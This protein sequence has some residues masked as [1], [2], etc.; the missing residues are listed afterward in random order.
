MHK[1]LLT[2]EGSLIPSQ[3]PEYSNVC[4]KRLSY[5]D[6]LIAPLEKRNLFRLIY[7][8]PERLEDY[9]QVPDDYGKN[10]IEYQEY[11]V[12]VMTFY[13]DS[14]AWDGNLETRD[15]TG[16]G[17]KENPWRNVNYALERLQPSLDCTE[18]LC[19]YRPIY[20]LLIKGTINYMVG[21]KATSTIDFYRGYGRLVLDAWSGEDGGTADWEVADVPDSYGVSNINGT[22][23]Y[24][25]YVHDLEYTTGTSYGFSFYEY[26]GH[27]T[28]FHGCRVDRISSVNSG[29]FFLNGNS[30][31]HIMVY[32][33]RVSALSS[34]HSVYGFFIQGSFSEEDADSVLVK[35]CTVQDMEVIVSD[36]S[37]SRLGYGFYLQY[38]LVLNNCRATNIKVNARK[39]N[40]DGIVAGFYTP[41]N[42][43]NFVILSGCTA[44]NL[45][46]IQAS[47]T[48]FYSYTSAYG[49][50]IF[51]A[52]LYHCTALN[53]SGEHVYGISISDDTTDL[54]YASNLYYCKVSKL[55][56]SM[57]AIGFYTFVST[58]Y[59][60]E[61]LDCESSGNPAT[62]REEEELTWSSFSV[63]GFHCSVSTL[64]SCKVSNLR[65]HSTTYGIFTTYMNYPST[66]LRETN[67][68]DCIVEN[69]DC[70][71]E[72]EVDYYVEAETYG[73]YQDSL[74]LKVYDCSINNL[75]ADY[76]R[77]ETYGIYFEHSNEGDLIQDCNISDIIS[78]GQGLESYG[79][80]ADELT[81]NNVN[82]SN[83]SHQYTIPSGDFS[84]SLF[85]C[86]IHANN[87]CIGRYCK[88]ISRYDGV[89][90]EK[91]C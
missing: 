12:D 4:M 27:P 2:P 22:Y 11:E 79:I 75:N 72:N 26:S 73:I 23:I 32:D 86:D 87:E 81:Y 29:G 57:H 36:A 14:V 31:S 76:I 60:C 62:Y 54:Q 53:I 71:I 67:L 83:V 46:I 40:G 55:L 91:D 61:V 7:H 18:K 80:Y 42:R 45:Q 41:T 3:A 59:S 90:E 64:I 77:A 1:I 50:H 28:A 9:S 78:T 30:T 20:Q 13:C 6:V 51:G 49:Y 89:Y 43:N 68:F 25:C 66:A 24:N 48:E 37:Y 16:D 8:A 65:S 39:F 58:L 33:C 56:G 44:E 69:C 88:S 17:T 34:E 15:E 63:R 52:K 47:G 38:Y 85:K 19:C 10:L 21:N 5:L 70:I 74:Y 35:A 82:V 84:I